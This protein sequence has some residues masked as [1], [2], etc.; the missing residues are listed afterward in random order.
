MR[1]WPGMTAILGYARASTCGQDLD[2]QLATLIAARVNTDRVFT[3]NHQYR[4]KGD[5]A[6]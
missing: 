1:Q 3:I 4:E 2:A 5:A 6:P